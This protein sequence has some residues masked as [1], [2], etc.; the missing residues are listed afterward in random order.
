MS[1]RD[2]QFAE[3]ATVRSRSQ[4][5]P[6]QSQPARKTPSARAGRNQGRAPGWRRNGP[7]AVVPPRTI[8]VTS[9]A[10]D[11]VAVAL[12]LGI[13]LAIVAAITIVSTL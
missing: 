6:A 4:S 12:G 10:L 13:G 1:V 5:Q 2:L 11:A 9:V 3:G 7:Q 8:K